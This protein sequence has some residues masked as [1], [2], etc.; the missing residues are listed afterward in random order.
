MTIQTAIPEVVYVQAVAALLEYFSPEN[1]VVLR[2]LIAQSPA[3]WV[4]YHNGWGL[5]VRNYLRVQVGLDAIL[6]DGIGWEDIYMEI[7]E[8]VVNLAE[9]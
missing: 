5:E 2:E 8:E 1:I 9:V 6:P 3:W 7:I 4:P